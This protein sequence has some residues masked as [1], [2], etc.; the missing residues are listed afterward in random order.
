MTCNP[1]RKGEL[2][3]F[4]LGDTEPERVQAVRELLSSGEFAAFITDM[5]TTL[6]TLG[7]TP[8]VSGKTNTETLRPVYGHLRR[9][10]LRAQQLGLTAEPAEKAPERDEPNYREKYEHLAARYERNKAACCRVRGQTTKEALERAAEVDVNGPLTYD[11]LEAERDRLARELFEARERCGVVCPCGPH[12]ESLA[13]GFSADHDG[14]H[15]W[16]SLPTFTEES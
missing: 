3:A 4:W 7:M 12:G 1:R 13:C 16:A 15:S 14:P 10:I 5:E 6:F 9:F 2:N 8:S 11:E